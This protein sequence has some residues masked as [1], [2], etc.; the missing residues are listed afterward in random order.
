[1]KDIN[2]FFHDLEFCLDQIPSKTMK[3][4]II[5]VIRARLDEYAGLIDDGYK[6]AMD[7]KDLLLSDQ[8]SDS[9]VVQLSEFLLEKYK[10]DIQ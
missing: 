1:M 5:D 3:L 2:N 8:D 7:E 6:L 10:E 9:V 4:T